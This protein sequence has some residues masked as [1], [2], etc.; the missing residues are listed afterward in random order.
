MKRSVPLKRSPL[1]R[2]GGLRPRSK[3]RAREDR[4]YREFRDAVFTERRGLCEVCH[5]IEA[6]G[7]KTPH[8]HELFVG[9]DG[10]AFPACYGHPAEGLHHR[11]KMSDQG[12]RMLRA[13]VLLACNWSNGWIEDNPALVRETP[14]LR[15]LCVR[16]GDPEWE[17]LGR[18]A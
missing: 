15:H 17:S 5:H 13:N 6:L 14:S 1:R 7:I 4:N 18:K 9:P 10:V 3:K 2:S 12:A 11:R 16:K 8:H